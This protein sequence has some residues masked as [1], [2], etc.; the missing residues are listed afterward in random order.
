MVE[1]KLS[2]FQGL[3]H[4]EDVTK[5]VFQ[6]IAM[7][8]EDPS[9]LEGFVAES[10]HLADLAFYYRQKSESRT[11]TT[12]TAKRM[13]TQVP[14]KWYIGIGSR[15]KDFNVPLMTKALDTLQ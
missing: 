3:E 4:H 13:Q 15:S 11:F 14:P 12:S 2:D 8:Q 1:L 10:R 5:V 9:K 7:L 6:Y